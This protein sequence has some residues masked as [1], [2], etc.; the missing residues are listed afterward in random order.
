MQQKGKWL[1]NF[2]GYL[3]LEKLTKFGSKGVKKS[4]TQKL[5]CRPLK[6]YRIPVLM[7]SNS[8][9]EL[10][11]FSKIKFFFTCLLMTR[12]FLI[13]YWPSEW[14]IDPMEIHFLLHLFRRYWL[15]QRYDTMDKW[16]S[17]ELQQVLGSN[18]E[19]YCCP[20]WDSNSDSESDVAA[21]NIW[22]RA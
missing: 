5:N 22:R 11:L 1:R 9:S 13:A 3:W 21:M 10:N 4:V 18:P 19:N 6:N 8:W 16:N 12:R 2:D 14:T 20:W 17:P 7:R 15:E